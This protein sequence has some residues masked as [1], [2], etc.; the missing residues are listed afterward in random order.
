MILRVVVLQKNYTGSKLVITFLK[1]RY[2]KYIMLIV[3]KIRQRIYLT[4]EKNNY[5]S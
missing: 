3:L 5:G 2:L 4:L 1:L